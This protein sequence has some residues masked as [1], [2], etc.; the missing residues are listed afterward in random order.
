MIIVGNCIISDDIALRNFECRLECCL[1]QCCVEGDAGAPLDQDELPVLDR[2]LPQV[3][4]FMT[5]EGQAA[6]REHGTWQPDEEGEP[7]TT[8]VSGRECAFVCWQG[9]TALCAIECAH[10]RGIIDFPKPLSCHLYPIRIEDYGEF[11]TLN[12]HQWEVCRE[13]CHAESSTSQPLYRYLE[14][15][16]VRKYGQAWYDELCEQ[17]EQMRRQHGL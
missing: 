6:V 8:L 5:A 15:P 16:L 1:G 13:A 11:Q 9:D 12:Y 4:P 10:R 7:C 2:L 17:C 14:V 3:L